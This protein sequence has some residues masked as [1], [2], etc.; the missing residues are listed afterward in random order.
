[1]NII[2]Q[3]VVKSA[4][5]NKVIILRPKTDNET[6][7]ICLKLKKFENILS[8]L[9]RSLT[10]NSLHPKYVYRRHQCIPSVLLGV[11]DRLCYDAFGTL[12]T[13]EA[14]RIVVI[15]PYVNEEEF[16]Q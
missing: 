2:N 8:S 4:T 13:G 12:D 6:I 15:S 9:E 10:V 5:E 11:D 3:L 1:M 7:E 14:W 16:K